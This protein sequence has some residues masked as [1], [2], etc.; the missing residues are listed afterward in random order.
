LQSGELYFK[1][2]KSIVL[3]GKE[4]T[5]NYIGWY[6]LPSEVDGSKVKAKIADGVLTINVP[7]KTEGPGYV[8]VNVE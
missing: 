4:T 7:R 6:T 3:D 1:G 5:R 8:R 2:S